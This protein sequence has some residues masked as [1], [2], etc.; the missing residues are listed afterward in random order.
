MK[1][2]LFTILTIFLIM[3]AGYFIFNG[4]ILIKNVTAGAGDNVSGFAWSENIGWISFNNTSGGG[5]VNYGVDIDAGGVFSGYAWSEN[6]GWIDFAPTGPYPQNPQQSVRV[7]MSTGVV[8][9][10]ARA[11]SY[12]SG[13]DGW[14]EMDSVSIDLDCAVPTYQEFSGYAWG[15]DVVGWINFNGADYGVQTNFAFNSDPTVSNLSVDQG[16]Y[17]VLAFHPTFSWDY[18]DVDGDPQDRYQVQIDDD[19]NIEDNPLIDSCVPLQGTCASGNTAKSY[20]PAS[21]S[22]FDYGTTYYWRVKVWDDECGESTWQTG[23][24]TTPPHKYPVPLFEWSPSRPSQ[25]ELIQFCSTAEI[26]RC[27]SD[28]SLCYNNAGTEIS[29]SGNS[30]VWSLPSGSEFSSSTSDVSENPA[31]GINDDGWQNIYLNI[32]DGVGSCTSSVNLRIS[33]PLPKWKEIAP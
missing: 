3:V 33:A 32:D 16:D 27:D 28:V 24:F 6:I 11:L 15:S 10:W 17:C 21:P 23:Q 29:C 31:A 2:I 26:G 22:S 25:S 14:I 19:V 12:G 1:K 7:N 4:T 20:I 18:T 9:G 5:G 8:T 30:F 13:W